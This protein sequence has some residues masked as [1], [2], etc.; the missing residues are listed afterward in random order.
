M[1]A[2]PAEFVEREY[3]LRAA[4]PD[5]PQWFA[6]W[7]VDSAAARTRLETLLDVRYGHGPKQTMDLFPVANARGTSLFIHG[8][9][10]RALD[11]SD[12]A[13]VA[14]PM[15]AR[16]IAV[17]VLNYDLCPQVDIARIVDECREAVAWLAREGPRYG[18]PGRPLVVSGHSAGAHLA[19]ML[20]A[21]DW[22]ARG[23]PAETIAGA[24][25]LSG[26][27]DLEPLVQ[28]SFNVDLRLDAGHAYL[29][30]PIHLSPRAPT[31]VLI[32]AGANETS[33][34]IR[35][36]WLLWERWPECHP[37][38]R[39]GPLFVPSRHHFSVVSELGDPASELVRQ[40]LA[41]F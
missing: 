13:F 41:L 6:R 8:G 9:Y 25:A 14:P 39:R 11:K 29:V 33:E 1:S 40:T 23:L 38:D 5:H 31:P 28:V 32:A 18:L 4:F 3:N 37:Q 10:W 27:F 15:V 20:V 21:T 35:Q 22:R 12:H 24:V 19:A 36:S 34:F 26:V 17:A 16:D 2:L 7:A 30:S